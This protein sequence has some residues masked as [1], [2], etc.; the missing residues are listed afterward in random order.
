[1]PALRSVARWLGSLEPG[2]VALAAPLLLFPTLRPGWTAAA[3]GALALVWLAGWLGTGQPFPRSPLN[4]ALLL[5]ALT[6]PVGVWAST[7]PDLTLPKLTGLLL[8][9]AAFRALVNGA[10]SPRSL[11]WA[12]AVYLAVGLGLVAVGLAGAFWTQKVPGLAPTLAQIPR[13]IRG[14]PGAERGVHP[15]ELGGTV[16]FF[17]PVAL[18]LSLRP[19]AGQPARDRAPRQYAIVALGLGLTLFFGVVLLLTQ[20]RSA[21]Y[22]V[23]AGVAA[24]AWLRWRW[25]RWP[26]LVLA[27]VAVLGVLYLG[28]A[29]AEDLLL[30]DVVQPGGTASTEGPTIVLDGASVAERTLQ[31]EQ[32]LDALGQYPLTGIGLGAFR[33]VAHRFGSSPQPV[34]DAD[35]SHAHNAFLQVGVD[36]GIVG[37]VA[38]AAL[39]ALALWLAG[40][41]AARRDEPYGWLALGVTGGL[42]AFHTFGI[43]DTIAPGAKPGVA[44]WMLLA[45]ACL[46]WAAR[47]EKAVEP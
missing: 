30:P 12:T 14:L 4:V 19:W 33:A 7:A 2:V 6:L 23:A 41:L 27:A 10:G 16:T 11:D 15:N 45:M 32:G 44:L 36:L 8:G 37:L 25:A 18:A 29:A 17:L 9:L 20:S 47:R 43:A 26:L 22:G 34:A 40:R 24:M 35:A 38:Y 5:L 28:P 21:W 13:L 46:L 1:M 39:V 42:V 3:L 31:W